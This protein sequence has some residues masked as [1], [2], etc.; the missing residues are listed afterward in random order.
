M[1]LEPE[2]RFRDLREMGRELLLLAG[3]RTRITWGLSFGDLNRAA[4]ARAQEATASEVAA[5]GNGGG[6]VDFRPRRRGKIALAAL[7]LLLGGGAAAY[8]LVP[9]LSSKL[10]GQGPV[11]SMDVK[12][13]ESETHSLSPV[14]G[15]DAPA[16]TA[17]PPEPA[18][19]ALNNAL[20]EDPA[21]PPAGGDVV[22][23]NERSHGVLADDTSSG[24]GD[25]RDEAKEDE[26][27]TKKSKSKA[28]KLASR[29]RDRSDTA[30]RRNQNA[31]TSTARRSTG[32]DANEVDWM[33]PEQ[34]ALVQQK[35]RGPRLGTNNAPILD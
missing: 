20:H 13:P 17:A 24:R 5:R 9:G 23:H 18:A 33:L 15:L 19:S 22:A 2:K 6:D 27:E 31:S 29:T 32:G 28:D 30:R 8:F 1:S 12:R 14:R 34:Q 3:Q 4:L 11:A 25:E 7:L 10:N 21:Q 35:P 26:R 16:G